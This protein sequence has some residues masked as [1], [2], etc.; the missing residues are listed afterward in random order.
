MQIPLDKLPLDLIER[1]A[2]L[3]E[4]F[5]DKDARALIET[6]AWKLEL[7]WS[8]DPERYVDP[9]L[10]EGLFWWGEGVSYNTMFSAQ[11][12]HGKLLRCL[13]D[14]WTLS[15]WSRW[16]A[17]GGGKR[18][19]PVILHVD[20]HR[21]F[22]SPRLEMTDSGWRDLISGQPFVLSDPKSV[23][24]AILSGAVGMGSFVTPFLHGIPGCEIRHLCQPP[25]TTSSL[26]QVLQMGTACDTLL[27]PTGHRPTVE[28]QASPGNTIG[29]SY[30]VSCDLDVWLGGIEDRPML[31]HVDMDYFNN[32]YDGDS[33][34]LSNEVR[35][36]PPLD[37]ILEKI[38]ALST[39]LKNRDLI[40]RIEDIVIAYSPGFFPAEFWKEADAKLTA[41]L[42]LA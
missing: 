28:L 2:K 16:L 23:E 11:R 6:D 19:P 15:S 37:V 22:G 8:A 18:G 29:S 40:E 36:D 5:G 24:A 14:S 30:L 39:A 1:H 17:D 33:D 3:R 4:Y 38:D 25:K 32:R 31:L 35:L 34:W 13:Y 7:Y 12:R 26:A 21:D 42:G 9:R 41:G 20:D 10:D 27:R